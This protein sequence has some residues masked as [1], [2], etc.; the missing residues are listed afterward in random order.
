MLV[1]S[2]ALVVACFYEVA[3]IEL[4]ELRGLIA[5]GHFQPIYAGS[6]ELDIGIW[7]HYFLLGV[8][9]SPNM[10]HFSWAAGMVPSAEMYGVFT[11]FAVDP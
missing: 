9:D 10:N 11:A 3:S 5:L 8:F 2:A 1:T 4:V 6:V 7:R